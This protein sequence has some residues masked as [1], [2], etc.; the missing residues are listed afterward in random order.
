MTLMQWLAPGESAGLRGR[1]GRTTGD[2]MT[3]TTPTDWTHLDDPYTFEDRPLGWQ[4]AGRQQTASGYG[5][6]LTSS[7][8]C[9]LPDG[10][11]RRVYV[12]QYSNSGTAWIKLD[13]VRRLVR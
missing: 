5:K 9:V 10:R 4:K 8:V 7:R 1:A 11:K 13:G 3:P 2:T 6:A 12:T